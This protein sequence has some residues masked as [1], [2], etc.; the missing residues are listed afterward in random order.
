[1]TEPQPSPAIQAF[2]SQVSHRFAGSYRSSLLFGSR[3]RGSA[4]PE[5]DTDILILMDT[6]DYSS[7][8]AILDL[9]YD[10]FLASGV[11][12]SPLVMSV[13]D[14]EHQKKIGIPLIAEIERDKVPL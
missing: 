6:V 4:R 8:R 3:A 13:A 7:K 5:S 1:M 2:I 14:Y 12:I 11:D 10:E 9:A